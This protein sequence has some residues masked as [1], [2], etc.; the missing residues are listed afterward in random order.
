MTYLWEQPKLIANLL[1]I[2]DKNDI[3]EYLAP[4]ISNNFY[5]NILSQNY[6][7]DNLLYVITLLLKEEIDNLKDI[8]DYSNFLNDTPCGLLLN[9]LNEKK[10]IQTFFKMIITKAVEKLEA[11]CYNRDL[12]FNLVSI[13]EGIRKKENLGKKND[14]ISF[15]TRITKK[16]T[17]IIR[18]SIEVR[19]NNLN[20]HSESDFDFSKS[21]LFEPKIFKE[22]YFTIFNKEKIIEEREKNKN[23]N[24]SKIDSDIYDIFLNKVSDIDNKMQDN[25][26]SNEEFLI[27]LDTDEKVK[28]IYME[29]FY[30]VIETINIIFNNMLKNIYFLPY[31]IKCLCKIIFILIKQKFP[32]I[33]IIEQN[34]FIGRFIFGKLFL[35][36]FLFPDYEAL[37]TNYLISKKTLSNLGIINNIF[38][39]LI[40][41]EL[42]KASFETNEFTPFNLFFLERMPDVIKIYEEIKKVNLPNF[43]EQLLNNKLPED[44]NL[45]YFNENQ[46]E[47]LNHRSICFK[48]EDIS[49]IIRTIGLNEKLFFND[50]KNKGLKKTF[51]KLCNNSSKFIIN[52][53]NKKQVLKRN[54]SLRDSKNFNFKD[55]IIKIKDENKKNSLPK[56][57]YFLISDILIN[58]KYNEIF[59]LEQKEP[60]FRIE[61]LKIVENESQNIQNNLIRIKNSICSILYNYRSLIK[62]DFPDESNI[63]LERI[64]NEIKKYTQI[65]NYLIDDSIP[66]LWF[67]NCLQENLKNI[68]QNYIDNDY[69]LLLNEIEQDINKSIDFLN[70]DTISFIHEKLNYAKRLKNN[71]EKKKNSLKKVKLNDKVNNI[72]EKTAIPVALH[73]NYKDKIL[74]IEKSNINI[75]QL[76]LRDD[77]VIE[78]TKKKCMICKTI[79]IFTNEFPNLTK[80]QTYQDIDLFELEKELALPQKLQEYF[81]L[82]KEH[83][84]KNK[85]LNEENFNNIGDKIY[86]YILRKLYDKIFP[87]EDQKDDKIFRQT[88][89]LT[90]IEPKHFIQDKKNY[91]FDG[92]LPDVNNYLKKLEKEKSPRKKFSYMSKIFESIRNLIK[93]NGG[94]SLTGVDDQM[95]IL[96]YALIK[97]RPL[98]IYSNCK[99]MELFLGDRRNKKEDSELIQLLSLCDYLCNISY[100]KLLNVTKEEFDLKCNEAATKDNF[101]NLKT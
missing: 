93:F 39:K 62:K 27:E 90:W 23:E 3:K 81:N 10:D 4:L 7:E 64:F 41:G 100:S 91:I 15:F 33:N 67:L 40:S 58:E 98:R 53:I 45:N 63:G 71:L 79:K 87:K 74:K 47:V 9:E 94:D 44:F 88:I 25:I 80:Y 22:K 82:I 66:T 8:N 30:R 49:A 13:E 12:F 1:S 51:E 20:F 101:N 96:N 77:L 38:Q 56:V 92:F 61:E 6:I 14:S 28:K 11:N 32:N 50:K 34:A 69:E 54:F 97:A 52:E 2:A 42:Y 18:N 31:S 68:P 84:L 26:Y 72:V 21:I 19:D 85:L 5:E 65:N 89:F 48:I 37:I 99:F 17:D 35:P 29:N 24:K 75:K 95:P 57:F 55:K 43:I 59:K 73:F 86:D 83:L 46:E 70:F 60:N 16:K 78:D 76:Q 36:F